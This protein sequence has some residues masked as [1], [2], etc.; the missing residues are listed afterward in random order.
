MDTTPFFVRAPIRSHKFSTAIDCM[1]HTS[2]EFGECHPL[3]G[4]V[5]SLA[6]CTRG[7]LPTPVP[8][9]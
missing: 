8:W 5:P 7:T 6:A 4:A 9:L 3:F 1:A 2:K